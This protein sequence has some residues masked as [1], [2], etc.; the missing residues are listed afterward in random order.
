M[1]YIIN[2]R[3]II[4]VK[5]P[6][7]ELCPSFVDRYGRHVIYT[8]P[9]NFPEL[10]TVIKE[11][12]NSIKDQNELIDRL[13][14]LTL[15]NDLNVTFTGV[16]SHSR[17]IGDV[18][19]RTNYIRRWKNTLVEVQKGNVIHGSRNTLTV[20]GWN[21]DTLRDFIDEQF[22]YDTDKGETA[23]F[24]HIDH[25]LTCLISMGAIR[26]FAILDREVQDTN[27]F[28]LALDAPA[29]HDLVEISE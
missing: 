13:K 10:L 17:K 12:F 1:G 29:P 25:G 28:D 2:P 4:Y 7:E 9:E 14:K 18:G 19:R 22:S 6:G 20:L 23:N 16:E 21:S 15:I 5:E 24:T 11:L 3:K 8:L 26:S 27:S